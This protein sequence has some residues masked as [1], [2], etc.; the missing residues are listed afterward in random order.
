MFKKNFSFK[1]QIKLKI[2]KIIIKQKFLITKVLN[3]ITKFKLITLYFAVK[4]EIFFSK[5]SKYY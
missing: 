5:L 4:F 1:F 2:R 3:L